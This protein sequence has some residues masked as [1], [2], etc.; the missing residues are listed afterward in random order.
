MNI[1][2]AFG[3]ALSWALL[4]II[5]G[6]I[7]HRIV[8]AYMEGAIGG[9]Q[10]IVIAGLLIGLLICIITAPTMP[11][12]G[13]VACIIV[14]IFI[15]IPIVTSRLEKREMRV[16]YDDKL[17]S[18]RANIEKDPRNLAA[19]SKLADAL[20]DMGRLNEA[21]AVQ[22][23]LLRLNP[24]DREVEYK[25]RLMKEE[26]DEKVCPPK[27]CPSC[28][29][30]NPGLRCTCESCESSLSAVSEFKRW[31]MAG[32]GVQISRSWTI[33][34]LII[35]VVACILDILAVPFRIALIALTLIIVISAQ[36]LYIARRW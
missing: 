14:A 20:Y 3:L 27:T 19:R 24:K 30:K 1:G 31:L 18:Y 2:Y 25:L 22:E 10:F 8:W 13:V 29:H 16:F 34:M 21:V 32:G 7:L 12:M 6:M 36:Y 4:G 17:Q 33:T 35:G 23:E 11:L 26:I 28:G 9:T 5:G 15:A